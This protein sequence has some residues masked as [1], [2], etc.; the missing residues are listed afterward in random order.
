MIK[1]QNIVF[2][3]SVMSICCAWTVLYED[4][5]AFSLLNFSSMMDVLSP[6]TGLQI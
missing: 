1:T 3:A 6:S 2:S 4:Q 5:A